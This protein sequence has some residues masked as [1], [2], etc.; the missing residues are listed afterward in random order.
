MKI[1]TKD[2]GEMEITKDEIL[3]FP[4][5]LFAFEEVTR[6][7]LIEK[8]G[9]TQKWLQSAEEENPR[10]IIFDPADIIEGYHPNIPLET[11]QELKIDPA[12][13]FSLYVIAVVPANIKDMTVNLKSPLLINPQK[14]LGAQI[15]LEKEDFPVRCRVFQEDG[16]DF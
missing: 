3:H 12:D 10:F 7:V 13:P 14:Q 16:G 1:K 5:G 11:F 6:F 15:I 2:F 4:H 9:C 8:D